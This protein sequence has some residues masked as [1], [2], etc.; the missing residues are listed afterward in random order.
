LYYFVVVV[1]LRHDFDC[2]DTLFLMHPYFACS[3]KSFFLN[4]FQ[5]FAVVTDSDVPDSPLAV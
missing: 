2:F 3:L 5:Q 4:A 1:V